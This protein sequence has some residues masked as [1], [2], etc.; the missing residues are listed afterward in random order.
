M[1]SAKRIWYLAAKSGLRV[2][3]NRVR[4]WGLDRNDAFI[5][6]YPRSGNTWLRF[7]LFDILVSGQISGFDEVNHIIAEVGLHQPAI[8]L[9]PGQGRLIKTHE[10]YRKPYQKAIYLVRDVRDVVLSEF[11]YQKALGWVPDDFEDFL[12]RFLDGQVNPFSPWHEHVPGWVN[13]PLARTPNFLLIK[14]EELRRNTEQVV[15]RSL[16]F[17]GVVVD[18]QIVRQAI[19]NN[20]VERMQEKEQRSPQLSDTAPRPTASE[21]SRFIRSGSVGGWR[22]RLTP[23]QVE[24]IEQRAG[25]V[26]AQMGYPTGVRNTDAA[27]LSP[28]SAF[29]AAP[30]RT[31]VEEQ[32][33]R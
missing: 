8:P 16:D 2:P 4:H 28:P 7:V 14:F 21:E 26:L 11:A 30:G 13:S 24:K 5:A 3:L 27:Q 25:K 33:S 20:T 15:N 12:S 29:R 6:S 1:I 17:L 32:V 19:A 10:A 31:I 22:N 18:P 23:V 9:L